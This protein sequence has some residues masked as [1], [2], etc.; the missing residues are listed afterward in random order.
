MISRINPDYRMRA[1]ARLL[2][3]ARRDSVTRLEQ[4]FARVAGHRAAVSFRYGRSGIYYLLKA[5][6]KPGKKVVMPSYTC[7]VVAHA[8]VE[9]GYVPVFVDN[10]PGA[11][12]PSAES[13]LKAVDADTVMVIPTHVFGLPSET[14]ELYRTVVRDYPG[15]FVLQDCAHSF[16][17]R[18][19]AGEVVTGYGHGA[20]F[21]MNISKLVNS[22]RGGMLTLQ[23]ERLAAQVRR[24]FAEE[25][26]QTSPL[27]SLKARAYG[28]A[29]AFAFTPFLY[30]IVDAIVRWTPFLNSEVN[31]YR[32][33]AI[34]LPSDFHQPMTAVEAEIGLVS[35]AQFSERV[36]KRRA[37][38]RFYSECLKGRSSRLVLPPLPEFATW[39]HFPVLVPHGA[40]DRILNEAKAKL[41]VELGQI[42]DYSVADLSAYRSRGHASCPEALDCAARV[43]NLP[44]TYGEGL[45]PIHNWK[46]IANA[47]C[48]FLVEAVE[49]S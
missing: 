14:A 2:L 16:F 32:P 8:V 1:I 47:I 33:D 6:G 12:Q 29:A 26:R 21:G 3:P 31:Y 19:S 30:R 5:L 43:V 39:S 18:D 11:F 34:D 46:S 35:L 45:Q 22:V 42:V 20:V 37:I 41:S 9:S 15:V 23:D 10:D 24:V 25:S 49:R 13:L 36:E 40:R 4:E 17:C 38:A 7:V 27:Q 44:L 28:L 48:E